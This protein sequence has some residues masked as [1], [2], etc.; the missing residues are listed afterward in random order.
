M[1][2]IKIAA[3][4]LAVQFRKSGLTNP[5]CLM[6]TGNLVAINGTSG[7]YRSDRGESM[8]FTSVW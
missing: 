2:S 6:L 3:Y 1:K 8:V 4:A 5:P 7:F